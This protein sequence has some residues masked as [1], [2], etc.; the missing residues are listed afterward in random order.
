M[1]DIVGEGLAPPAVFIALLTAQFFIQRI[2]AHAVLTFSVFYP[3][4]KQGEGVQKKKEGKNLAENVS[5]FLFINHIKS[6]VY[7]AIKHQC[8]STA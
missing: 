2:P 7:H 5:P 3:Q 4:T 8:L 6:I 1:D